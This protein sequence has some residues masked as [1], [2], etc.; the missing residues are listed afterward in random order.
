MKA[1]L[2]L[3]RA[4][5]GLVTEAMVEFWLRCLENGCSE[6]VFGSVVAA[7]DNMPAIA[8]VP[9]VQD[10]ERVFQPIATAIIR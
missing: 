8:G 2:R 1:A 9:F 5:S 6:S 4:R 7:I 10:V 3:S